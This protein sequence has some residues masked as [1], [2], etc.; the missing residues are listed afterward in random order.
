MGLAR[1]VRYEHLVSTT[2]S[3]TAALQEL[4]DRAAL[5]DLVENYAGF[6][7]ARE[8]ARMAGLFAV[9]GKLLVA[10]T[11]GEKPTVE[12]NGRAEIE[13]AMSRLGRYHS[14]THVIGNVMQQINGDQAAG[15]VGCIAHHIDGP[16]GELHDRVLY[17]RYQDTY[18][19][20]DGAWQFTRR[21][22]WV[23]ANENHPLQVD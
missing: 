10:L 7:D 1:A 6:A 14:T 18:G 12:R 3:T 8:P 20:S 11:P 5:R 15:R 21:E 19:K 13:G 16:P 23:V 2:D 4:L 17:I 9:D 22:V